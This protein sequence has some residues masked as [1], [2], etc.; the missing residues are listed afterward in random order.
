M[1][2]LELLASLRRNP[3]GEGSQVVNRGAFAAVERAAKYLRRQLHVERST[4]LPTVSSTGRLCAVAWPDRIA[5]RRAD[6]DTY[7]LASGTGARLAPS[8]AVRTSPLL[9]ALDVEAGK[10]ADA[11][12]RMA[13]S[14]DSDDLRRIFPQRISRKRTIQWDQQAGRVTG[15]SEELFGSLVLSSR[16]VKPEPAESA[17]ALLTGV[18]MSGGAATLPWSD[19]A[20][21]FLARVRFLAA[22]CPD[23]GWPDVSFPALDANLE[24]WLAPAAEGVM[25]I[26]ALAKA[27][28][29][30]AVRRLL[31]R[32]QLHQLQQ[33]APESLPVPSGRRVTLQYTDDGPPVLA[34]KLQEMFGCAQTPQVAFGRVPVVVHLLSPAGRPL[35]VTSDLAG[36]WDRVYPEVKKEMKGR[37]PRHPWPDDPWQ[38]PPTRGTSKGNRR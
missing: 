23:G 5:L 2:R 26:D 32:H 1:D 4:T 24:Q 36:F 16:Q 20:R 6:S 37:Y 17:A 7:L 12:I 34:V 10:G 19:G 33:G 28:L 15:R 38:A 25:T 8:T 22:F 11:G 14:L 13:T 9:V 21:H 29:E 27:E 35:Q 3:H 18:R 31:S 30:Q